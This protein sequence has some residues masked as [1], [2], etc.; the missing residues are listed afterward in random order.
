MLTTHKLNIRIHSLTLCRACALASSWSDHTRVESA[1]LKPVT[2]P[3]LN[4]DLSWGLTWENLPFSQTWCLLLIYS[5]LCL[6]VLMLSVLGLLIHI[7]NYNVQLA[8]LHLAHML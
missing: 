6:N 2:D 8:R 7:C 3:L 5:Q 1:L 4:T